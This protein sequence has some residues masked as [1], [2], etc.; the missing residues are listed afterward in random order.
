M[1][2]SVRTIIA[3]R[4]QTMT[5]EGRLKWKGLYVRVFED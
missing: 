2:L 4:E 1:P 3:Q 5:E